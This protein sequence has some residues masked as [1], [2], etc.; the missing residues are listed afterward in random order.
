MQTRE[1]K[2]SLLKKAEEL[3]ES[4]TGFEEF[5]SNELEHILE[6]EDED[7]NYGPEMRRLAFMEYNK[8]FLVF[9]RARSSAFLMV[10]FVVW[11]FMAIVFFIPAPWWAKIVALILS[12]VL[13]WIGQLQV[14]KI[15]LSNNPD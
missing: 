13:W 5:S 11:L 15:K 2:K 4:A 12:L 14:Y 3:L 6:G 10:E 8:R 9:M 7:G 1:Q